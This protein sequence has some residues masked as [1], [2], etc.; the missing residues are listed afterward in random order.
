M[1]PRP[2]THHEVHKGLFAFGAT[3]VDV[4][5]AVQE[6]EEGLG[7]PGRL[8]R[9]AGVGRRRLEPGMSLGHTLGN[10]T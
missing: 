1:A 9:R 8:G 4:Y 2:A 10:E 7:R 3:H 5:G 6:A